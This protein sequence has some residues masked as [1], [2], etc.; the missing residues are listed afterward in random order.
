M[1][2]LKGKGVKQKGVETKPQTKDDPFSKRISKELPLYL[3]PHVQCV[4][5]CGGHRFL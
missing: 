4:F 2:H 3:N 5:T 1:K